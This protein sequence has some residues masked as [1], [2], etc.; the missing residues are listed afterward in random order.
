MGVSAAEVKSQSVVNQS[1]AD[2]LLQ[3]QDA[4]PPSSAQPRMRVHGLQ[5]GR[6]YGNRGN[7]RT[8]QGKLDEA[9]AD[10]NEA[11]RL[12]PWSPNPVLNRC[13]RNIHSCGSGVTCE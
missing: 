12:S 9:L 6:A 1:A 11:I 7:A 4:F 10:F 13:V 5:V 8:R 2:T 3:T